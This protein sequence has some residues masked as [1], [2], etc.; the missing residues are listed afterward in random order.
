MLNEIII[1]RRPPSIK[2]SSSSSSSSSSY[3]S[4]SSCSCSCSSCS[5]SSSCVALKTNIIQREVVDIWQDSLEEKDL[6][7]GLYLRKITRTQMEFI[8]KCRE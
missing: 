3:F 7:L 4:C 2:A 6:S 5:S 8:R 1:C